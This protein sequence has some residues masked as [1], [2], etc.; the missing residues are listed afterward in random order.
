MEREGFGKTEAKAIE[1]EINRFNGVNLVLQAGAVA[2]T[3]QVDATATSID[4][5]STALGSNLT[6]TFYS[7]VPVARNVGS[8]FYTAPASP[9]AAA[10]APLIPPLVAPPVWKINTLLTA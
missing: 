7:E 3:V 9:M 1:V 5:G 8:L 6:S 2:Q 4:T 10:P